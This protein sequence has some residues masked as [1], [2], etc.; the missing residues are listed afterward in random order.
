MHLKIKRSQ[1][2]S[3]LMSKT[4]VFCLDARAEF[5]A[6]EAA[7]VK[8]YKLG[9]Q[10]IYNSEKSKQALETMHNAPGMIGSLAAL[11]KHRLATNISIEDLASGKHIEC[12]DLDELLGAENAVIEAC[13]NL[14]Q[15]LDTVATFDGAEQLIKFESGAE[16]ELVH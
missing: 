6:E 14:R 9:N 12:K 2:S 8:K 11:A 13:K 10:T 5:T 7:N 16:P 1:K 3:G 4:V 15:Y